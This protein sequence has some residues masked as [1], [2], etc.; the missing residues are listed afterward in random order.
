M[1]YSGAGGKLIHE[2]KPEAK[3][4]VTLSLLWILD[5]IWVWNHHLIIQHHL[6][7][8]YWKYIFTTVI[9]GFSIAYIHINKLLFW[10]WEDQVPTSHR[11]RKRP[12]YLF[13]SLK[14]YFRMCSPAL[15]IVQQSPPPPVTKYSICKQFVYSVWIRG[16]V[17]VCW[18]PYTVGL[19]QSACVQIH[20]LN[21]CVPI[22]RQTHKRR[23]GLKQKNSCRKI[24]SF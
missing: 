2:K 15:S 11:G 5:Y 17:G 24:L 12:R 14:I 23:G 3:N 8:I 16:F 9:L 20:N 21:N 4:L 7:L 19:L 1:E 13:S 22:Q 10:S 18:R 6:L